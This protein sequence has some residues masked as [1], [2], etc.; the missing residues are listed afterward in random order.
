MK[1]IDWDAFD[2]CLRVSRLLT[3][4]EAGEPGDREEAEAQAERLYPSLDPKKLLEFSQLFHTGEDAQA[5]ENVRAMERYFP[6]LVYESDTVAARTTPL[7]WSTIRAASNQAMENRLR[8]DADMVEAEGYDHDRHVRTW[9]SF[10]VGSP[11]VPVIAKW[12]CEHVLNLPVPDAVRL[13]L[14]DQVVGDPLHTKFAGR[15]CLVAQIEIYTHD[16]TL[17]PYGTAI[18]EDDEIVEVWLIEEAFFDLN[19]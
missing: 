13:E 17:R 19:A 1:L 14:T 6:W 18:V 12:G 16:G 7:P 11:H 15:V 2:E 3:G 9:M 10:P 4:A 5:Q 8:N